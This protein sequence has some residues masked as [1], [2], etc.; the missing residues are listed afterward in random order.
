MV[1]V[2]FWRK[3]E[4][5]VRSLHLENS[6]MSLYKRRAGSILLDWARDSGLSRCWTGVL[7]RDF[8]P[9]SGFAEKKK[10]TQV[11]SSGIVRWTLL[12]LLYC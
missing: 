8:L 3:D 11:G 6:C 5:D 9:G 10:K 2:Q 7:G 12:G 1:A 4:E